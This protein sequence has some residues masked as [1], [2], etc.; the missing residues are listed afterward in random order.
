MALSEHEQRLLEEMERGFYASEADSLKTRSGSQKRPSYRATLIALL[1]VVV[2]IG[3]LIGAVSSGLIWL[4]AIGFAVMLAAILYA[5]SPRNQVSVNEG[6]TKDKA[7]E[8]FAQ[9]AERRWEERL[10]GDR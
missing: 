7:R 2:G 5:F 8:S 1:G 3:V 6:A 9:K 4:G 10:D